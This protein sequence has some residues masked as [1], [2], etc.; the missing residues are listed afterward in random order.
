[1][2]IRDRAYE[3]NTT[4]SG[5]NGNTDLNDYTKKMSDPIDYI[6][7]GTPDDSG[8]LEKCLAFEVNSTT[9]GVFD[10]NSSAVGA[11]CAGVQKR[12]KEGNYTIAGQGVKF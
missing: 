1:M 10:A 4:T 8:N 9:L 11:I 12:V 3:D 6:V 5:T 2:C 7:L